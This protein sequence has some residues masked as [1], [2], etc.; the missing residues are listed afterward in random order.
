M[1]PW[2]VGRKDL[3]IREASSLGR[4]GFI[5]RTMP[6]CPPGGGAFSVGGEEV[7]DGGSDFFS[8]LDAAVRICE[9]GGYEQALSGGATAARMNSCRC[10]YCWA[11]MSSCESSYSRYWALNAAPNAC[12]KSGVRE[13]SR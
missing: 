12:E 4:F 3:R 13:D 5:Q 9:K 8:M 2:Q 10:T 1:F 6:S 11:T 7:V